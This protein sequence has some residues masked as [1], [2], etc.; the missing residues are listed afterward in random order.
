MSTPA[1]EQ[2]YSFKD[3]CSV[4]PLAFVQM[5]SHECDQ[6]WYHVGP[7][8]VKRLTRLSTLLPFSLFLDA[9]DVRKAHAGDPH[10]DPHAPFVIEHE[11]I[12][13]IVGGGWAAR[14]GGESV[15]I[16]LDQT[17]RVSAVGRG[18]GIETMRAG[19][20]WGPMRLVSG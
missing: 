9:R 11:H 13:R 19:K 1:S 6:Q 18:R 7:K 20:G 10:A 5:P 12:P 2:E 14:V 15:V 8:R 4:A 3:G 17:C 16:V